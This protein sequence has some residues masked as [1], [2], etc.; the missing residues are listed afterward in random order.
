MQQNYL[1]SVL[2]CKDGLDDPNERR[3]AIVC[4]FGRM[5]WFANDNGIPLYRNLDPRPARKKPSLGNDIS[6]LV[7]GETYTRTQLD[8][9]RAHMYVDCSR[10]TSYDSPCLWL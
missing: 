8:Q 4:R 7:E 2:L 6:G 9:L 3:F 5:E 1:H 10:F